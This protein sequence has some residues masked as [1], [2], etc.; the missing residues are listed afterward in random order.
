[1]NGNDIAV[2]HQRLQEITFDAKLGTARPQVLGALRRID[3][4]QHRAQPAAQ[5]LASRADLGDAF[6]RLR[7]TSRIDGTPP[8]ALSLTMRIVANPRGT[9]KRARVWRA[10]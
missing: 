4:D 8:V 7:V 3:Q 6:F 9:K 10:P 2:A 1:R 5:A